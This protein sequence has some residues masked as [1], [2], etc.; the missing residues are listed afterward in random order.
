MK[1]HRS[2]GALALLSLAIT[3]AVIFAGDLS[4]A[5][6]KAKASKKNGW[7]GVSIQTLTSEIAK[8]KDLKAEE[9]VYVQEVVD[10]SPAD[11]AGIEDGDVIVSFDGKAVKDADDFAAMVQKTTPGKKVAIDLMRDGDRK[12]VHAVI[13]AGSPEMAVVKKIFKG[14]APGMPA[15]PGAPGR[16]KIVTETRSGLFGMQLQCLNAQLGEY[17]G[18]PE[19][20]G[21]LVTE[22]KADGKAS[23]AGFKAG[24][25]I[26]RSGNKTVKT[27]RDFTRAFQAYDEGV[28]VPVEILRKGSKMTLNL[29]AEEES[30]ND[31]LMNMFGGSGFNFQSGNG[32][33]GFMFRGGDDDLEDI[34]V[35]VDV[36]VDEGPLGENMKSLQIYIDKLEGEVKEMVEKNVQECEKNAG[37]YEQAAKDAQKSTKELEKKIRIKVKKNLKNVDEI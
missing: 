16:L 11:S 15:V 36:D 2:V 19:N 26:V 33:K 20:K 30:E 3:I 6:G 34:D 5:Q 17:F 29:A 22:V 21:L 1:K 8:V 13:S 28:Q 23:K 24:D 12:Q 18:A 10:D 27:V 31:V 4:F 14:Y 9:G 32:G 37:K 25:V 7:L 35:D